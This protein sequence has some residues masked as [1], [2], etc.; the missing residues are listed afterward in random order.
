MNC[1]DFRGRR[2]Y[3]SA[4]PF[5]AQN[6]IELVTRGSM[7]RYLLTRSDR[8]GPRSD[9]VDGEGLI[10][11]VKRN[12]LHGR[13]AIHVAGFAQ[14][15]RARPGS[16]ESPSCQQRGDTRA[17]RGAAE[18]A[19]RLIRDGLDPTRCAMQACR[20]PC[21]RKRPRRPRQKEAAGSLRRFARNY[22]EEH[23]NRCDRHGTRSSGSTASA[24]R[25]RHI[26]GPAIDSITPLELFDTLGADHAAGAGDRLAHLST[27]VDRVDAR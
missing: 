21:R 13:V 17:A 19:R 15:P 24:Q 26:P 14:A 10:V 3:E 11:R 22:H 20:S 23:A 18:D 7:P 27:S 8:R 16:G 2:G 12:Q 6:G 1:A 9:L 5:D 25:A 4:I